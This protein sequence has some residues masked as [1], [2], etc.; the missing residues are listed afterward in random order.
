MTATGGSPQRADAD[1]PAQ[2]VFP[3][4]PPFSMLER[5]GDQIALIQGAET[6]SYKALARE[7]DRIAKLVGET[8]ALTFLRCTNTFESIAAYLGC[9]RGGHPVVLLSHDADI[10]P[11]R[12]QYSPSAVISGGADLKVERGPS[13]NVKLHPDLRVLLT[14]SGSTGSPKLVRL[15][16]ANIQSNARSIA[17]F[18]GLTP[19]DRALTSLQFNYSYGLSVLNSH[20]EVGA[21]VVLTE[22]SVLDDEFWAQL[23]ASKATSFAGVPYTYEMLHKSG[24]LERKHGLR[25]LTQAGGKL[26]PEL[27]LYFSKLGAARGWD[28]FVMYGQTEAAPRMGYLPPRLAQHHPDA[29]GVAIPGGRFEIRDEDQRPIVDPNRPGELVYSGPNVMMGYATSAAELSHGQ[30]PLE[31]R[32]GDIAVWNEEKLVKIVGRAARFIKLF[33]LRLSL[34]DIEQ[35]ARAIAASAAATGDDRGVVVAIE[36][37]DKGQRARLAS[38]LPVDL[39]IPQQAVEVVVIDQLPRLA[40]GKVNYRSILQSRRG[41]QAPG[42]STGGFSI[43]EFVSRFALQWKREVL[44]VLG[45]GGTS[46]RSVADIYAT[47]LNTEVEPGHTFSDLSGDS[48]TYVQISLALEEYLGALPEDWHT[49][50]IKDLE[51]MK[52][53]GPL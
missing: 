17:D 23:E 2:P 21:S 41:G 30:G 46:W 38:R 3:G 27:V 28:F 15:S 34:D 22:A 33:G 7:A 1:A 11:L 4:A 19:N 40:N 14:T 6:V 35:K 48:L 43:G 42:G 25:Y 9:L 45:I 37:Q 50:K 29:I 44:H 53:S 5:F 47:V 32:T 31:L 12:T 39:K 16:Q 8:P 36:K 10:E 20:F 26:S 18:L 49:M 13:N 24:A 52:A 51:G